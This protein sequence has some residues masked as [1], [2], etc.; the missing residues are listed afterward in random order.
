MTVAKFSLEV[1][2]QLE[3]YKYPEEDV[4][5]GIDRSGNNYL[6]L[7]VNDVF[8]AKFNWFSF[9]DYHKVLL[10]FKDL[11][12][13]HV[14]TIITEWETYSDELIKNTCQSIRLF[15]DFN[16][17]DCLKTDIL[18][19]II[20]LFNRFNI[21]WEDS[22]LFFYYNCKVLSDLKSIGEIN[23]YFNHLMIN[24]HNDNDTTNELVH[25]LL[26]RC[27][28]VYVRGMYNIDS[29]DCYEK[30]NQVIEILEID[31]SENLDYDDYKVGLYFFLK[32]ERYMMELTLFTRNDIS[33]VP[34]N[35]EFEYLIRSLRACKELRIGPR[36]RISTKHSESIYLYRYYLGTNNKNYLCLSYKLL[37]DSELNLDME[38]NNEC[39]EYI[40][41]IKRDY[42]KMF[43]K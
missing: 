2:K 12:K 11:D 28:V 43:E 30:F 18:Y 10:D 15:V 13:E 38:Y 24:F 29:N 26:F 32:L 8:R 14:D 42:E 22:I 19:H 7:F 25:L 40:N 5:L 6:L 4:I 39:L 33:S 41:E 20:Q 1:V 21:G 34:D 3:M 31:V 23:E 16:V 36:I 17:N 35:E 9:T 27:C 37:G